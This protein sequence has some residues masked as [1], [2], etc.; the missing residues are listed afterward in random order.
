MQ[1]QRYFKEPKMVFERKKYLDKLIAKRGNGLVKIISGMRRVGKTYLL[2]R[3][4][5]DYL[6]ESGV[7]NT[8]IIIVELDLVENKSLRKADNLLK[9]IQKRTED[10]SVNY[11]V[12]LDEIQ[13][14]KDFHSLLNSL[15]SRGNL[16]V[17]VTGSNSKFL[18]KD[19]VTEFR[20]RSDEIKLY[21]LTFA[22]VFKHSS[23]SKE[24]ALKEYLYFGGIPKVVLADSEEEK[25]ALLKN[26]FELTYIKDIVERKKIEKESDLVKLTKTLASNV[27]SLTNPQKLSNTFISLSKAKISVYL[28]E[29]YIDALIDAFLLK[30]ATRYSIKGKAYISAPFKYYFQD[31]GIRNS[32]LD[33]RQFEPTHLM[34]NLIYNELISREYLVDVGVVEKNV[35]N[36]NGNG[37]RVKLEVDFV[38]N[39]GSKRLYIQSCY[40]IEDL[41]KQRI[42]ERP[43]REIDDNFEKILVVMNLPIRSYQTENGIKII[44]LLYFLLN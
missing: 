20:G 18:S 40:S 26:F 19:I 30:K 27:G 13:L 11:Y 3:L 38:A 42:E 24:D 41:E 15:L 2:T 10:Q 25:I 4:Y 21:P 33:F 32:I 14:V 34:E 6:L 9:Y 17:Y 39:K 44:S 37:T 43:F 1:K 31:L 5:R 8:R 16:D 35:L 29:K 7:S 12:F 23:L 28:I 22:E 36:E